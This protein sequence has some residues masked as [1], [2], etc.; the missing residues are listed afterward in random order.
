M[1]RLCQVQPHHVNKHRDF[2]NIDDSQ[3]SVV[4]RLG[5]GGYLN[6]TFLQISYLV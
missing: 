3:S 1:E 4:T 5:C 6:M 2:L